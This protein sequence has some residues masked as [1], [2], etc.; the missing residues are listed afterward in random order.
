MK[1]VY[2][3]PLTELFNLQLE[4]SLLSGSGRAE[5][6]NTVQGYWDEED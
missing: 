2:E 6:M 4:G 1:K 3:K 5:T